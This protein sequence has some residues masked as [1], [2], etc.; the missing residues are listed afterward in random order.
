MLEA[1]DSL[2]SGPPNVTVVAVAV[3]EGLL[4]IRLAIFGVHAQ[5]HGG[6]GVESGV[7]VDNV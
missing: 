6:C 4:G 3:K 2:G 7:A 5:L 1:A